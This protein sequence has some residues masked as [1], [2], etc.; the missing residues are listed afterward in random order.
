MKFR[1]TN[2]LLLLPIAAVYLAGMFVDMME[3]DATQYASMAL[4]MLR[5]GNYLEIYHRGADYIDKPPLIFWT[6]ALS[7]KLFGVSNFSYK[8]PSVLFTLLGLF[9]T[10]RFTRMFYGK[11]PAFVATLVLASC[12]AWFQI[13]QDVRTDTILA[14]CTIFAIW[15]LAVFEGNRNL[16]NLVLASLGIAGAMLTKGPIGLMVPALAIATDAILKRDWMRFLRWQ[17]LIA[18]IIVLICLSPMLYGLWKQFDASGGK[19]TYNGFI[20]SGLRFYFWTQSFG[21]LTGESTWS[22]NT[23]PFFFVHSFLWS[24]LPWTVPAVVAI[25]R[26]S[27][28][29]LKNGFSIRPGQEGFTLGG[30]IVPGIAFSLSQYKLPHYIF[31]FFPLVAVLTGVLIAD[32]ATGRNKFFKAF[33]ITQAVVAVLILVLTGI[34]ALYFFPMSS[35]WVGAIALAGACLALY[36]IVRPKTHVRQ[37]VLPSLLSILTLNFVFNTHVYPTMLKYES[38]NIAGQAARALGLPLIGY[39]GIPYGIDFYYRGAVPGLQQ[40]TDLSNAPRMAVYT[41]DAG[42]GELAKQNLVIEKDSVLQHYHVSTLSARF[43][44]PDRRESALRR[45]HLVIICPK[46]GS[47]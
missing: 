24:F 5:T 10:F 16:L 27:W 22:N 9:A 3:A 47:R 20:S 34:F 2:W 36:A 40:S 33:R 13:N 41:D 37:L 21:R 26:K 44:F 42:L 6:A 38:G 45:M 1:G 32:L 25:G 46:T 31:V 23:G 15:Q 11:L 8:L 4:E 7:F 18:G 17:W 12:H 43:L 39:P 19:E 30:I 14:A 35:L 28:E 29:V